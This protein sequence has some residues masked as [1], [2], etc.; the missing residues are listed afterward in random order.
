M[1]KYLTML[2]AL[3]FLQL[4][5]A[6][7]LLADGGYDESEVTAQ[8][9]ISI[10]PDTLNEIKITAPSSEIVLTKVAQRWQLKEYPDLQIVQDK[11]RA[12]TNKLANINVSWPVTSTQN[13]HQRFKVTDNH[14]EKQ[15]S[16]KNTAGVTQTLLLGD[17]PSYK[18]I[19]ARN[20]DNNEV[21][22]IEFNAYQLNTQIND[23]LDKSLLSINEVTNI[24][25]TEVSLQ[26][27]NDSWQ[28]TT[29]ATLPEAHSLDQ[30]R[31]EKL[32]AH[33]QGLTVT[34]VSELTPAGNDHEQLT[35]SNA[36]GQQFTYSFANEDEQYLVSRNDYNYWFTLPKTQF[37]PLAQ[38][39]VESI[40]ANNEVSEEKTDHKTSE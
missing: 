20:A 32:V 11:V 21:Y 13:S 14:F 26:K 2:T 29:P 17:S 5:I 39:S 36:K 9:L 12:L 34:K 8:K 18:S 24:S 6:G 10:D 40:S 30:A 15:L 25:H 22:S 35:V 33:L 23:W 19:Y 37:E 38:L 16:V 28:L 27:A 31:I 1:N 3:F 7:L 4:S